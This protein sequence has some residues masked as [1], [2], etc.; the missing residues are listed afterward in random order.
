MSKIVPFREDFETVG[1]FE[2]A[3]WYILL[4]ST[5]LLIVSF[6]LEKYSP[7]YKVLSDWIDRVN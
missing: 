6:L 2:V 3:A 5:L 4:L 1:K 7:G